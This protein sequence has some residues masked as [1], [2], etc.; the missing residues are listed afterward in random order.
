ML[1][2]NIYLLGFMG[3]GKSHWGKAM[4]HELGA[5]FLDLDAFIEEKE[6]SSIRTIFEQKGEAY[7]RMVEATCLR[8]TAKLEEPTIIALGGGTPCFHDNMTWLKNRGTSI[9][10]DPPLAVLIQQL[11]KG[12]AHRP[13]LLGMDKEALKEFISQKM[14]ERRP[15]YEQATIKISNTN[16]LI[17]LVKMMQKR[18]TLLLLHGALGSQKQLN[19]IQTLLTK[20]FDVRTL[21]FTGHGGKAFGDAPFSIDLFTEDVLAYMEENNLE[22]VDIFGYSMGGY[23]AL[24]LARLHPNK[25]GKIVTLATKFAWSPSTASKEVK[26]LNPVTIEAKV[27]AFAKALA[28]RHQ[29]ED[30]KVH[31]EKTATMMLELGNGKALLKQD[32]SKIQHKVL[33]GI[34]AKDKMVSVEESQ[35]IAEVLTN[36][37]L[38]V[39]ENFPHPIEKVDRTI[40]TQEIVKF[41]KE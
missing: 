24:N 34:G 26:M 4:A 5:P 18:N 1:K 19:E 12:M 21:N 35:E 8:E 30:W 37:T 39:F 7:F 31:L 16:T 22:Q 23:V 33:V 3:S 38:L 10:L 29:P 41:L 9:F 27:P 17:P 20:D 13:L 14:T 11:E 40:L 2:H 36:G 15:F 6:A 28:A 25:V 32:F